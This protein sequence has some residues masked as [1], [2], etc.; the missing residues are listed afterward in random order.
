ML[1]GGQTFV[2]GLR[3]TT[4]DA[5]GTAAADF[6]TFAS[7]V[8]NGA[9]G[10]TIIMGS[11]DAAALFGIE[12][13]Q[14]VAG[15][16][17]FPDGRVCFTG[18]GDCVAY[19]AFTGANPGGGAPA[20]APARGMALIREGSSGQD[21]DDF[22]LGAPAPRNN[23]GDVGALGTCPGGAD[24]PTPTATAGPAGTATPTRTSGPA[25]ACVGDCDVAGSV[26]IN[27]LILGVNI[28]LGTQPLSACAAFD[29]LGN[30]T[31]PVNCLIQGVNNSL[32]GCAE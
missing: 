6:G 19:G 11:A 12:M 16:L 17:L 3:L 28:S 20:P 1:A 15:T 14:E 5:A 29:C 2:S 23:A 18:S 26:A 7:N 13:D 27:E 24:T 8:P 25:P 9:N 22:A 32:N 30:G 31:V 21:S 10:S 4:Q